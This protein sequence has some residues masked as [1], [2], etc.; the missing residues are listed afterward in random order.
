MVLE[1][2]YARRK[3]DSQP[4]SAPLLD[5]GHRLSA[6]LIYAKSMWNMFEPDAAGRARPVTVDITQGYDNHPRYGLIGFANGTG[7]SGDYY[8]T[9]WSSTWA[10]GEVVSI[11][12][13]VR[14][15]DTSGQIVGVADNSGAA[16]QL[17]TGAGP[18][19][20]W[21]VNT[22]AIAN[23]DDGQI[24]ADGDFHTVGIS[25]ILGTNAWAFGDGVPLSSTPQTASTNP[26]AAAGVPMSLFTR[27]TTYPST[28]YE[29]NFDIVLVLVW[30][31]R[32]LTAAD[33]AQLYADP[34]QVFKKADIFVAEGND[35][36]LVVF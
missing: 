31:G 21:R 7:T 5:S 27:W 34:W 24:L 9:G 36:R 2:A 10:T 20:N 4:R 19:L 15:T 11:C 8:S 1:Q 26:V 35:Q 23:I 30:R 25:A 28:S 16:W 32:Y 3:F 22:T 17:T 6:G 12:A 13:I 33:H 18:E 29:G 14:G